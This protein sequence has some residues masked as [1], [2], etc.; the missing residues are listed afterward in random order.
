MRRG[1][2]PSGCGFEGFVTGIA[3]A[4]EIAREITSYTFLR[5]SVAQAWREDVSPAVD[6]CMH[7]LRTSKNLGVRKVAR[8]ARNQKVA[9]QATM[10]HDPSH[11]SSSSRSWLRRMY[12]PLPP[13]TRWGRQWVPQLP[14]ACALKLEGC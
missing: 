5:P 9:S 7:M 2:S 14:T 8:R 11:L 12:G 10:L 1:E 6:T 13:H 4:L 3:C